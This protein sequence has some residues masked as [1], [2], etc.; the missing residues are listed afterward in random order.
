VGGSIEQGEMIAIVPR[1]EPSEDLTFH[2]ELVKG[3]ESYYRLGLS[4]PEQ[5]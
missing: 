1:P 5:G 3:A 4:A 2:R